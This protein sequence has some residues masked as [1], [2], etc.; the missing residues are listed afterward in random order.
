M[1]L[2]GAR[3]YVLTSVHDIAAAYKNTTTLSF[4]DGVK[5]NMR[6]FGLSDDG[7]EKLWRKG[8]HGVFPNPSKKAFGILSG[9][10]YK[11]QWHPGKGLDALT[12]KF[13][14]FIEGFLHWNTLPSE[15]LL[16]EESG[17]KRM[18]LMRL[19]QSVLV[20]AGSRAIF[21]RRLTDIAPDLAQQFQVFDQKS[22]QLIYQ[23][24]PAFAKEMYAAKN[25]ITEALEKYI[26]SP[27]ETKKDRAWAI[28]AME[29]EMQ[30]LGMKTS[31]QA[32]MFF[33]IY[34]L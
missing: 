27:T 29:V 30:A 9:E 7:S 33:L 18:S 14:E 21:G 23:L 12:G 8:Y 22:W 1:A 19:C 2:A 31:D 6:N 10:M 28:E 5:D 24:P 3:I 20:D 16:L 26:E 13:M 4:E 17:S 15:G 11:V 32:I 34:W 25:K